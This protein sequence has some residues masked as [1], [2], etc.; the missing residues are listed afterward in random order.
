MDK[1]MDSLTGFISGTELG[2]E[3]DKLIKKNDDFAFVMLDIDMLFALNRDYG[4][5][6]GDEVFKLIAR[7]LSAVFPSPCLLFRDTRDQFDILMPGHTK[8]EAFLLAETARKQINTEKLDY[9]SAENVPLTQ[10]VSIGIS[11]FPDDG[12][13]VAEIVRKADGALMRAKRNGR[14]QVCLAREEKMITKT[15]HYTQSQLEKLSDTA[16]KLGVGEAVLLREALDDILRK[17]DE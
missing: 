12:G 1:P 15:S 13:R 9:V 17:Y 6:V 8:E 4:H 2:D 5:E 10:S 11:S 3:M 14:N 7:H 16:K